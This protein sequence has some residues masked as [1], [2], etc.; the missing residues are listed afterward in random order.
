MTKTWTAIGGPPS[1]RAVDA[2]YQGATWSNGKA[3]SA[4][5][6]MR[7]FVPTDAGWTY[8]E[9]TKTWTALPTS[10]LSPR[11]QH[12]AVWT[13]SEAIVFGGRSSRSATTG[14]T[15]GKIYRP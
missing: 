14:L 7:Y 4:W 1:E 11:I 12:T 6:G 15:D 5:G 9:A 3:F 13:G 10:G 8:D 2:L